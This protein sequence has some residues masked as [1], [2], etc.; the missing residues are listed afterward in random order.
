MNDVL[1][2]YLSDVLTTKDCA[3]SPEVIG[4]LLKHGANPSPVQALDQ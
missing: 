2:S 1:E 4:L 3:I